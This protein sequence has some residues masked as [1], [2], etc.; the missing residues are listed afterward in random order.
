VTRKRATAI[1][2]TGKKQQMYQFSARSKRANIRRR[3]LAAITVAA[4]AAG[5]VISATGSASAA[6]ATVSDASFSWGLSGEQGGGAFANGCNFLSAGT[7]GDTGSSRAW[8]EADG[9]YSTQSGNVKVEKPNAS[10]VYSQPTWATKCQTPA[11]TAASPAS[12]TSLTK[13][14]V[15]FSNGT[16]TIDTAANTASISW[17]GS[18]TSAFYGGLTYWSA[19]NPTLTVNANGTAA[20]T[21]TVAGYGADMNDATAWVTISPRTVTLANLQGV[22]VTSTGFTV[23]P[24]YVGVT[25]TTGSG[26]PQSTATPATSGAFPQSF[27]DFQQLTGQSSY[28]YSSGGS[29]DAAKLT[30][31]LGVAFTASGAPADAA[32]AITT[33]PTATSVAVGGT[34]SFTAA[35]SGSPAP[36]VQWQLKPAGA[37]SW[38]NYPGATN[39][40]W[41]LSVPAAGYDGS[42]VRA[43]FT[44]SG[45]TATTDEVLLTV[46]AAGTPGG[47]GTDSQ[48]ITA[49]VPEA[50]GEFSWT[51]DATSHAVT[52]STAVS[53]GSYLQ[54]TGDLK[55]VKVTDTRA[56]APVWSVSGQVGD[57]N[58][59]LSGKY[60][61]WTPSVTTAGA[62]AT[63]GAAVASGIDAGN[64][65]KDSG[66]LGSATAGHAKGTGTLG[67]GLDLRVPSTTEAGTYTATLTLTALS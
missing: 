52:L 4:T 8:T 43:V 30:T 13:N 6:S 34:A 66:T 59:A 53:H 35:A 16:G 46:T 25:V 23:T 20:L 38:S 18:F 49:T 2:P 63:A 3:T 67:A 56:G 31:P 14:R 62:G 11:G 26:T 48:T 32:P 37:P 55:P 21:A 10:D 33:Q 58:N 64:G 51:I 19:S 29:R 60:L 42:K 27:V 50:A 54:S 7:A 41:N 9:F 45:G 24:D 12:V 40:T 17:T 65:L 39:A 61:G 57:F 1:F 28:W 44:N 47:G 5:L 22:T 36:T 15:L